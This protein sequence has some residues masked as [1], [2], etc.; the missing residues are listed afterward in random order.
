MGEDIIEGHLNIT[1]KNIIKVI[2]YVKW[3]NIVFKGKLINR[4]AENVKKLSIVQHKWETWKC[5]RF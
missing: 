2:Q 4:E 1:S 5:K 3:R